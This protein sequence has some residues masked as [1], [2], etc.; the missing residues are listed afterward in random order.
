MDHKAPPLSSKS[1]DKLATV[2]TAEH[3]FSIARRIQT[4]P[5]WKNYYLIAESMC[6]PAPARQQVDPSFKDCKLVDPGHLERY[7]LLRMSY[8]GRPLS[9]YRMDFVKHSFYEFAKHLIEAGAILTLFGII[10]MDLHGSNVV[11]D[12]L[13]VPRI[14]DFNLAI[15]V[16]N[17]DSHLSHSY[18]PE[19]SQ[20]SPDNS[21]VKAPPSLRG[22]SAIQDIL[23]TKRNIQVLSTVLGISPREQQ[24]QLVQFY[25]ISKA[26][27]QSDVKK[28]FAH[29]WRVQDSWAI[30]FLLTTLL[31]EM[32][33]WPSFAQ[34]DYASYSDRIL[35]V[36]RKMCALSPRKRIDCVQALELLEPS[37]YLFRTYP[38]TKE[39]LAK[40][41]TL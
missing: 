16:K 41:I 23:K 27:Q 19:L 12:D 15:D 3:E 33:R 6:V 8:G 34:S 7:R 40:V 11:V 30:G 28:W 22:N 39:W 1:I 32:S 38:V 21:L 36:L 10:H 17:A 35:P 13:N 14:I 2:A 18:M 25:R 4:L 5:L 37:H 26:V 31:S 24:R 9:S 29:Y 20:I